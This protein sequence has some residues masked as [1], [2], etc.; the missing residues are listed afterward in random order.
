MKRRPRF[1]YGWIIVCVCGIGLFLGP[2]L[3]VFSFG[4]IFKPLA[5]D[6]HASRAAV[7]FAFSLFNV[8]GALW[9]PCTGM[10][11]DRFG[12]KRV[13]VASTL[14][15]GLVLCSAMLVGTGL[16]QLYLLFTILGLAMASGPAPVSPGVVISHWFDR[17][18][19]LALG[20]AMMGI[21]VGAVVVPIVAERLSAQFGWRVM[22]AIF[23]AAT[24]LA[25]LPVM[26]ALLQ[27]DPKERGLRPD[28]DE[29]GSARR[30]SRVDKTGLSWHEIWHSG[31]FW[32]M[33]CIFSLVGAGVHGAALHISAIFTDRAISAERAALATSL[34]GAAVMVG[35]LGSGLLLDH[36]FAPRV[37]ILF[38]GG[39]ALGMGIL[40]TGTGGNIAFVAAF[41]VGLGMGAEV[42]TMGYMVS[43][44]F[45]LR[46]FGTAYGH[47]FGAFMIA[48]A[49]GVTLM[50]AGY[51]HW[52]SYTLPLAGF[53]GAMI[54]VLVL[55]TRLGPYEFG[56]EPEVL[57]A[58]EP[59]QV[60]SES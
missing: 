21:G 1:F 5:A 52:H 50:G 53:C 13:I 38:Y 12:A 60:P 20:L 23:G 18:R 49:A 41:L 8:V 2:P 11:I 48:G 59:V 32:M 35:R 3:M 34:V 31:T 51:D 33:I 9:L 44:Y 28:G 22:F 26:T 19:G 14:V 30:V 47:V 24:L 27:N 37:A 4:V 6:F 16:W 55:L 17:H 40:A 43:R 39:T 58:M 45:G 29:E 36:V 54:L 57:A 15:Y 56:V 7:S 25:P 42:E 10:L 46:A